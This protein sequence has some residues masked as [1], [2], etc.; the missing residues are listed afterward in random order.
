[1]RGI[2]I[3]TETLVAIIKLSRLVIHGIFV[4]YL[5]GA[6]FA[7]ILGARFDSV[8]FF[9][10]YLIL[11]AGTLSAMYNNNYNDMEVDRNATQTVFSGGSRI[12][13]D[14]PELGPVVKKLS[15]VFFL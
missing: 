6:L 5:L 4:V 14:H 7:I 9:F 12:L 11:F 15:I 8:R 10:V 2:V 3:K 13:I 1:M